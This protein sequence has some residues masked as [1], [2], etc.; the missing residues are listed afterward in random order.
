MGVVMSM[1]TISFQVTED[2]YEILRM[3]AKLEEDKTVEDFVKGSLIDAIQHT[4]ETM[5]EAY[6][7]DVYSDGQPE[8][9][10]SGLESV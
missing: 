3:C 8:K 5:S 2:Q 1:K 10:V 7:S 6:A 9:A 4:S